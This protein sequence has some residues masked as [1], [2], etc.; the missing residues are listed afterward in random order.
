MWILKLSVEIRIF[1]EK[2]IPIGARRGRKLAQR[3]EIRRSRRSR[4]LAR[5]KR[6]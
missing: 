3:E 2:V 5:L 6:T 1:V 4:M